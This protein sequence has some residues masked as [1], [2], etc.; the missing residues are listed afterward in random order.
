MVS[1]PSNPPV[2]AFHST[3]VTDIHTATPAFF[4]LKKQS[5]ANRQ[6]SFG[7]GD[8]NSGHRS[9]QQTLLPVESSPGRLPGVF[10][11]STW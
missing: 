2:S 3:G 11:A 10:E 9:V 1:K 6:T 4:Q 8:S 7:A 5:K